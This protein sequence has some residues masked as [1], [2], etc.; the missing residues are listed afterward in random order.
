[1]IKILGKPAEDTKIITCHLGNGSSISAV[2]GGKVID[3]SMGFTPLDGFIMGS[4]C[5]SIDPAIVPFIMEKEGM[6]PAEM[7][8]FMNKNCGF[9]GVSGGL[10][11]DCRNL[12]EA[13]ADGNADAKLAI[14]ILCYQIKKYIG[15]YAAAMNGLDALVFT[16]GIGE[17][18]D[19]KRSPACKNMEYFGIVLDVEKNAATKLQGDNVCIS[20]PDS[21]VKV[22]VIPTNEELVIAKDTEKIVS[23]M[24]K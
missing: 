18:R 13:I 24:R 8:N 2:K 1:M 16:A 12:G 11:S 15:A 17:N 9:L 4:R 5:G 6:T 23:E 7:N 20:T 21:K 10:S 3:T 19:E 14:D 22:Y